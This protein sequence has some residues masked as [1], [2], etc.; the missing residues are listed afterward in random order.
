MARELDQIT[1]QL[2]GEVM[3][4]DLLL[5]ELFGLEESGNGI[6]DVSPLRVCPRHVKQETGLTFR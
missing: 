5:R 2:T 1:D 4:V 6:A 3:G